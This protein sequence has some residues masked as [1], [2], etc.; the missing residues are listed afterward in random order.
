MMG[1]FLKLGAALV[2]VLS[3]AGCFYSESRL[4]GVQ[5]MPAQDFIDL[6]ASPLDTDWTFEAGFE[7]PELMIVKHGN[8]KHFVVRMIPSPRGFVAEINHEGKFIFAVLRP[9]G[10]CWVLWHKGEG[11]RYKARQIMADRFD[12]WLAQNALEHRLPE[13]W[14]AGVPVRNTSQ[15]DAAYDELIRLDLLWPRQ[16][17][18]PA[19]SQ[20]QF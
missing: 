12:T 20:S 4:T 18:C 1:R 11:Y 8:W 13:G 19:G 16:E 10:E 7:D 15:I 3:L 2:A 5:A 14:I 17:F 6:V 9:R